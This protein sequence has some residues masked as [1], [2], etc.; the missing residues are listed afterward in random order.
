MAKGKVAEEMTEENQELDALED[1]SAEQE[2]QVL[3]EKVTDE[4]E[5][6]AAELEEAK[7]QAAEYLDGWQRARAEF[8]NYRRRQEQQR[9]QV[10]VAAKS[11]VLS[12]LLPVMDDLER[13]FE[14]VPEDV[15][16]SSWVTGLSLVHQKWLTALQKVG[17]SVLSD[18]PGDAFDPGIHEALTHEPNE[19]FDDGSIIQVIQRG[20][21]LNDVILRPALVRVSSGKI[22]ADQE[23]AIIDEVEGA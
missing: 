19:T 10:N 9:K 3:E 23:Q 18:K 8:A 21:K 22:Q 2:E 5:A 16:K 15:Q 17:V 12:H 11:D 1:A 4:Q 14:A 6:L 13:A 20:Y 7:G